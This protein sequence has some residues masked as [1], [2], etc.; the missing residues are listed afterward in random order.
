[1]VHTF[2]DE[3]FEAHNGCFVLKKATGAVASA[4]LPVLAPATPSALVH[5]SLALLGC[6]PLNAARAHLLSSLPHRLLLW[7]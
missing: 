7:C 2:N 4:S 5:F 1:M 6:V 3:K